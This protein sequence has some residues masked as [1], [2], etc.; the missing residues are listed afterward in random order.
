MIRAAGSLAKPDLGAE[1]A[2]LVDAAHELGDVGLGNI[3]QAPPAL[4]ACR[5]RARVLLEQRVPGFERFLLAA[6]LTVDRDDLDV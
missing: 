6:E 1:H 2:R 3:P 4:E 5:R